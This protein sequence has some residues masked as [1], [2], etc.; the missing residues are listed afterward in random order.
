MLRRYSAQRRAGRLSWGKKKKAFLSASAFKLAF[1]PPPRS[2][3]IHS[4]WFTDH[5]PFPA[6]GQRLS[7]PPS[8]PVFLPSFFQHNAIFVNVGFVAQF[9]TSHVTVESGAASTAF[10]GVAW[11][12]VSPR[13]FIGSLSQHGRHAVNHPIH[14]RLPLSH[15]RQERINIHYSMYWL[16]EV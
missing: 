8:L 10:V 9:V 4:V 15:T 11:P 3:A 13:F 12:I 7:L 16:E 2:A 5:L 1:P 14:L 6:P